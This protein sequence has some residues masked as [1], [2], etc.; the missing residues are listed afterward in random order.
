MAAAAAA[1]GEREHVRS[2][3]DSPRRDC[4]PMSAY[5][6]CRT[7]LLASMRVRGARVF[8]HQTQKIVF[9]G[10]TRRSSRCVEAR[11]TSTI[12]TTDAARA[13]AL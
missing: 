12:N 10:K 1:D 3:I 6:R 8:D 13:R 9:N 4:A 11:R 7:A 5:S 2:S